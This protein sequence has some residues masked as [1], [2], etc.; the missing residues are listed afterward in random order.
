MATLHTV[1]KSPF[2][3][4]T[5]LS[6]LNHAKDG[7]AILMIEDGIYGG[8]AGTG[9]SDAVAARAGSVKICVLSEDLEA[10]GLAAD[11]LMEGVSAVG[12]DGFVDLV[13]E[14]DRTQNWL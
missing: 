5:L 11:R 4:Q 3:T 8:M 12:Y 2:M 7:D 14:N 9:L 6:C 10:R 13:A 1:N